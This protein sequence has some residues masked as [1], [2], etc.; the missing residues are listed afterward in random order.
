M[1]KVGDRYLT[2]VQRETELV[3]ELKA[4]RL[5]AC[6]SG[7]FLDYCGAVAVNVCVMSS[8]SSCV[9]QVRKLQNAYKR[10]SWE[11]STSSESSGS[12]VRIYRLHNV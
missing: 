9:P 7:S 11:S 2:L 8:A 1:V 12:E 5:R 6:S 4:V 3:A 10:R